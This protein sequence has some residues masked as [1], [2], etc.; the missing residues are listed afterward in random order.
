[1]AEFE[2][3]SLAQTIKGRVGYPHVRLGQ[4]VPVGAVR[5]VNGDEAKKY[6]VEAKGAGVSVADVNGDGWDDIYL[7]S[8]S[9][10]DAEERE[11]LPRNRLFLSEAGQRFRDATDETGLGDTGF[12][13]G[14]YFADVDSDGD[15]DCY[16]TNYGPNQ[17]YRNNGDG[18]F[19][20]VPNAGGAINDGLSTGAAF[21]DVNGDGF[22][23]LYVSN[24]AVFSKKLADQNGPFTE[25]HGQKVFL[26]PSWY[27][28]AEDNL[29]LNRGD[30]TF[31]D[32]TKE[33]GIN[34]FEC[35]RGFTV[36]FSDLDDDGDLDIY[37]AN[38]TTYNH[39][40]RNT[41]GGFFEDIAL[42]SGSALSDTGEEQGGMGAAVLDVDGDLKLDVLVTNYQG[43]YNIL[44]KNEGQLQ[45]TDTTL[46]SGFG[47]GSI[48][49]VCFG[50]LVQDFDNDSWPDAHVAAGHV[51]PAA[52]ELSF[53]H[54][55]AQANLFYRNLGR[56][57]FESVGECT[58]P[59][60]PKAVSRGSAVADFDR[61]GDL[62][63]ILNNLDDVPSYLENQTP[64][65]N[66]LQM[67]MQDVRGMPAYGAR[68]TLVH[69]NRKQRA[70]LYSSASFL[71]QSSATL[72]FGLGTADRVDR[73]TVRWPDGN[74]VDLE[75]VKAN[76]RLVVKK[77]P[78]A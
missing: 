12:G 11:A 22:L 28:P 61:D 44:Y 25:F 24:Y 13:T 54:G 6:I 51:Y 64:A 58:G 76:Q 47:R 71:S 5:Q 37:V 67:A 18:R 26:G 49:L 27:V 15:L 9:Y 17:L 52:D 20:V 43:E 1:M 53:F 31:A 74:T 32:V 60:S 62:D 8:G 30:G 75:N 16:L 70:E 4:L 48:P 7:V 78:D 39:L 21:A 41:G 55:Y 72:H 66:W 68:I 19:T 59:E 63:I 29:F 46:I 57:R 40:Y 77:K 14:A 56:A 34:G 69:G 35:G 36:H 42:L 73:I 23:D 33:R 10:L 38:D 45:F 50:L 3:D 65:G 2:P